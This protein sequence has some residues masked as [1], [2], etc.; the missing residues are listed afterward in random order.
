MCN[1]AGYNGYRNA[2]PILIDM[3][4]RQENLDGGLSTGI[5]TIHNG[6]LYYAKVVGNV[7]D[8][9]EK[10][11]ALK[12]PGKIG[13]IHSRPDGNYK[14]FAH[15]FVSGNKKTAL[16]SNG[17]LCS[18][19]MLACIRNSITEFL[20]RQYIEFDSAMNLPQSP[21]PQLKD[22]R[23]VAYGEAVV[24]TVEY[25]HSISSMRYEDIMAD[26]AGK[27]FSD[28]VNVMITANEPDNIYVARIS[29]P[30][31]ILT[32]P[33]ET[34]ISTSQFGFPEGAPV[35]NMKS[36]PQMK[37]CVVTKEG[38]YETNYPISG[39][40]VTDYTN[41]EYNDIK[42]KLRQ[43]LK[44]KPTS[45]NSIGGGIFT[46]DRSANGLR[47]HVKAIYDA[48]WDFHCEGVLKTETKPDEIPW[49]PGAIVNRTFFSIN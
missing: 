30:M 39:G 12:F 20:H 19:G 14:E 40:K 42:E 48:L 41:E 45:M 2:A 9:I 3:V 4:R 32:M 36:L 33:G 8:L 27:F 35:Q 26:V 21:Y 37:S 49:A 5:A 34:Y 24:K 46:L 44:E 22:G 29:R 31:N 47:P 17:N 23:Y 13:I 15:P 38:F 16:V 43:Q 28:V 25:S 1:I 10:T 11:D 18:D 7:D 6:I